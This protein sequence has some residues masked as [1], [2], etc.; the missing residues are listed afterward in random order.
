MTGLLVNS[1]DPAH[2]APMMDVRAIENTA[3]ARIVLLMAIP[4]FVRRLFIP[5][6]RRLYYV[7]AGV[8]KVAPRQAREPRQ[9]VFQ[10]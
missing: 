8:V 2:M 5:A 6:D 1:E 4:A 9:L 3:S 7:L 10:P